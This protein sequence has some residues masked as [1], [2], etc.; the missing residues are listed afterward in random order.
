[1]DVDIHGAILLVGYCNVGSGG[2]SGGS[3]ETGVN[4]AQQWCPERP[5]GVQQWCPGSLVCP[6]NYLATLL[7]HVLSDLAVGG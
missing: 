7:V 1:M 2:L 5:G 4:V 6:R 3:G